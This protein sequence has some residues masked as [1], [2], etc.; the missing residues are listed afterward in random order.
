M[1]SSARSS[2]VVLPLVVPLFFVSAC[3]SPANVGEEC[4]DTSDCKGG[5]SCIAQGSAADAPTV[6]MT[7]CDLTMTR[8]CDDGSVCTTVLSPG[9][10]PNV[11]VCY[12][13]GTTG[14]GSPCTANLECERGAICVDTGDMQACYRACSTDTGGCP[15]GETCAPLTGAGT[16]GFCQAVP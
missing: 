11:G 12:L 9:R 1:V 7:D 2:F 3:T 8:L 10:D 6:C 5:L 13:G 14:V 16:D 15:S 4:T